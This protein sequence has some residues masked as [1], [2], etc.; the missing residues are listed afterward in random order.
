MVH[1][2]DE[3]RHRCARAR[4][5]DRLRGERGRDVA[6]E[7]VDDVRVGGEVDRDHCEGGGLDVYGVWRERRIRTSETEW[8]TRRDGA[9]PVSAS[10]HNSRGTCPT[11]DEHRCRQDSQFLNTRHSMREARTDRYPD[12]ADHHAYET[13]LRLC[14]AALG[15]CT[16][17]VVP[18]EE[19]HGGEGTSKTDPYRDERQTGDTV[20]PL[21]VTAEDDRV[22][23]EEG[24]LERDVSI[25]IG[26][27]ECAATYQETVNESDI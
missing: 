17:H 22:T 1:R 27:I 2:G 18:L 15:S 14:L 12:R 21:V 20:R 9:N 19:W 11:E 10:R 26:H 7:G 8:D 6:R 4:P 23:E 25:E 13:V 24:V 3:Q 5:H 16:R